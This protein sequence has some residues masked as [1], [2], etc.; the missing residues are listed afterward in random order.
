V[1][2]KTAHEEAI[3]KGWEVTDDSM[4][5]EQ[6][7]HEV[8]V[9]SGEESNIKITTPLDLMVAEMILKQRR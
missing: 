9:V 6:R 4:L 8:I 7:G 5:L 3:Q 1:L 2:L